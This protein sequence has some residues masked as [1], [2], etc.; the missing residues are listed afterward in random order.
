MPEIKLKLGS[1]A[2]KILPN[3]RIP[4]G[5]DLTNISRD[6]SVVQSLRDDKLYQMTVPLYTANFLVEEGIRLQSMTGPKLE[7]PLLILQGSADRLVDPEATLTF[8]NRVE[9]D[10]KMI[11]MIEGGYHARTIYLNV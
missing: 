10:D 3:F 9:C 11:E 8:Y 7:C 6:P 1:L 4:H 5:L 2:A